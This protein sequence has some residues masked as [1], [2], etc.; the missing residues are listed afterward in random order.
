MK[1]IHAVPHFFDFDSKAQTFKAR[2]DATYSETLANAVLKSSYIIGTKQF[3]SDKQNTDI[4]GKKQKGQVVKIDGSENAKAFITTWAEM[5]VGRKT[6]VID[7]GTVELT[8]ID[9]GP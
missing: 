8:V 1:I 4:K 5:K 7:G 2:T 6:V 3:K 9:T